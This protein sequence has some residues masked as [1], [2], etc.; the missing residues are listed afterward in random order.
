MA[1]VCAPSPATT[2][3]TSDSGFRP[4]AATSA[5]AT[6]TPAEPIEMTP[7]VLPLRSAILWMG[8]SA[9]TAIP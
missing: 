3:V 4:A 8:L 1:A 9:G 7:I 2:I 5:L 6:G